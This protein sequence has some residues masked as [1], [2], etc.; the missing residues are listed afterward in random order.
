MFIPTR[1]MPE[2]PMSSRSNKSPDQINIIENIDESRKRDPNYQSNDL[3]YRPRSQKESELYWY[4]D[5]TIE[6]SP[7]VIELCKTDLSRDDLIDSPLASSIAGIAEGVFGRMYAQIKKEL[8]E[9]T[10][11]KGIDK[12]KLDVDNFTLL[13]DK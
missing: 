11:P 8:R 9:E 4:Q 6:P 12:L 1:K 2:M 5:H 7:E 3:S 13:E 10:M